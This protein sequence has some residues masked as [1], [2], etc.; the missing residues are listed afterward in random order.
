MERIGK[1]V[2]H[3]AVITSG[4]ARIFLCHDPDLQIPVAI[5]L[6]GPKPGEDGPLSPAQQMTRFVAEARILAG[7]DHPYIVNVKAL[8][9][10]D[11]RPY[12]VMPFMAAHLPYEIGKD[13]ADAAEAAAA[14]ERDRPRRLPLGRTL[15]VM[16][17]LCSA[18]LALHRRGMVHRYLKPSNVLLNAR[19]GGA[20]KLCDFSVVK[21][22]ERNLPMPDHWMGSREYTAPEQLENATTVTPRADVYS[23]GVIAHRLLTGRLP[24]GGEVEGEFPAPLADLIRRALSP[25]PAERP[26][27][28]GEML[29]QLDKVQAQ[30]AA[31][32]VVQIL[33]SRR[34]PVPAE[35]S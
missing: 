8:D 34:V 25:D 30:Q 15:V 7:F 2:I 29:Q 27:H 18:V 6:F 14:P 1:Y 11:G 21:L 33:P 28:A 3:K 4:Y 19:E 20:T 5:K 17:Q 10:Q 31:K 16:K 12:F 13:F 32:P 26:A 23:L 22:P 9:F 24:A 35:P